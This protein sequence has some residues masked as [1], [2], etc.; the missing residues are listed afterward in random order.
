MRVT[1]P[2]NGQEAILD[3]DLHKLYAKEIAAFLDQGCKHSPERQEFRR[4]TNKSG[5][6]IFQ[7]QCLDCGQRI[8]SLIKRPPNAEQLNELDEAI[9]DAY[10][11]A[12][13]EKKDKIDQKYVEIQLRRWNANEKG[14]EYYTQAREAYMNSPA[15]KNL[16]QLVMERAQNLCEGC[17]K[18]TASEV[19]HLSY[20]HLRHEFLFELVALCR[21]CH[22][23]YHAK[24][25]HEALVEGCETCLHASKGNFCRFFNMPMDM[26]LNAEELCTFER[27]HFEEA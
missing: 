5:G 2:R 8:G 11:V 17:R 12:Q 27:I 20:E 14:G 9:H 22:T 13:K 4:G 16:R 15:W 10:N 19:H 24:G 25:D 7:M 23:R 1:D 26:A 3:P 21:D 18:K 6:P